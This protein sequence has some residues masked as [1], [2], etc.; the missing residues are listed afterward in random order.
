MGC[1]CVSL[2]RFGG[3]FRSGGPAWVYLA[4]WGDAAGENGLLSEGETMTENVAVDRLGMI[5]YGV[6]SRPARRT[7]PGWATRTCG[8]VVEGL[9]A[10]QPAGA[11]S[12][13]DFPLWGSSRCRRM[14][15]HLSDEGLDI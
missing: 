6:V 11:G 3:P 4:A 7:A 15:V 8:G 9:K 2:D 12:V 1:L 14:G 10:A 5:G 13:D